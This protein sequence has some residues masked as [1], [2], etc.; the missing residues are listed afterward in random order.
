MADATHPQRS[1]CVV[2]EG[3]VGNYSI[4]VPSDSMLRVLLSCCIFVALVLTMG[5]RKRFKSVGDIA[6]SFGARATI[7]SFALHQALG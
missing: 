2:A 4:F 3:A 6:V 1:P 5:D 7:H